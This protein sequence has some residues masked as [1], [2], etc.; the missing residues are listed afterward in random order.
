MKLNQGIWNEVGRYF[1]F[2]LFF[3]AIGGFVLFG[4]FLC[5]FHSDTEERYLALFMLG[6][7]IIWWYLM[8][9]AL[10][11]M[12]AVTLSEDG[13]LIRRLFV[14]RFWSWD[15]ISQAGILWGRKRY[16]RYNDFVLLPHTGSPRRYRDKTFVLRN[17]FRLIHLPAT[18]DVRDYVVRHYGPLDFDLSDGQPEQSIVV[19]QTASER[20]RP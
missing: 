8:T 2:L 7:L 19:D 5:L 6:W 16:G 1:L 20:I 15:Q 17:Q 13:V 12:S 18:A 14:P 4:I 3:V 10:H 9:I 11:S